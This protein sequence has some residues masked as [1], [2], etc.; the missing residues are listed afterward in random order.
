MCET[1]QLPTGWKNLHLGDVLSLVRNG[2]T[3]SQ[4]DERTP[5]PVS[6]IETISDG[7][8]DLTK[9]RYLA[10][11][12]PGYKM[13]PGDILYSHINSLP[14]MGK[15]AIWMRQDELYHG[16]NL[17][18]LRPTVS[19]VDPVFLINRLKSSDAR[20]YARR[21]AKSAINQA[22]L[23]QSQIKSYPLSLPPLPEQRRIAR[24]LD[25]VDA[26][27]RQTEA[28]IAKLKQVKAGLLHDLLTRG[29]D[30]NGELRDPV[31]HP[32][33]FKDSPLGRVPKVWEVVPL[34]H[35]AALQGGYAFRSSNF[36]DNGVPVVR[37]SD[38]D[39]GRLN[40]DG[41]ARIPDRLLRGL[42]RFKLRPGDL[43][44]GMSGSLSNYAVVSRESEPLYLNQRV[45]R[46]VL[47]NDASFEYGLLELIILSHDYTRQLE[48]MAAG[49]AQKN[50]SGSQIESVWIRLPDYSE[51]K[52]IFEAWRRLE[53]RIQSETNS[54]Q[55]L[56]LTK[57]GLMQD[58]LTGRVRV[59]EEAVEGVVV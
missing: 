12:Q 39:E 16:M 31:R 36:V 47:T 4:T 40:L 56:L 44:V 45:G 46:F 3:A 54:C 43:L 15:V 25:T 59:P 51:Q 50:V 7:V 42:D 52:R 48:A 58:L 11:P 26:A 14:H 24:V 10:K 41:C 22:S 9:V 23:G 29:L 28:V 13:R 27:I 53:D 57:Q 49:A 37:M 30:E 32:E 6:R 38:L 34:G 19:T 33:Q 1:A 20:A 55:K 21:E 17:M 2:T 35:V 5:Y 8:V 18:L